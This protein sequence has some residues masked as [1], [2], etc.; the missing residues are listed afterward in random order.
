MEAAALAGVGLGLAALLR[1][2]TRAAEPVWRRAAPLLVLVL[3][4]LAVQAAGA[5]WWP[6]T[7]L[8]LPM[9]AL[10]P[11]ALAVGVAEGAVGGLRMPAG[12]GGDLVR[13][14]VHGAAGARGASSADRVVGAAWLSPL[15][16]PAWALGL[17][18]LPPWP[19]LVLAPI[20]L[21]AAGR[22]PAETREAA[23]APMEPAFQVVAT[24]LAGALAHVSGLGYW[25]SEGLIAWP[26]PAW[27]LTLAALGVALVADAG[28]LAAVLAASV[29][30]GHLP[31][32]AALPIA[33]GLAWPGPPAAR[34][35]GQPVLRPALLAGALPALAIA[36]FLERV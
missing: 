18:T 11:A 17:G 22:R 20:A 19:A 8:T 5:S 28:I 13:G 1:P 31:A 26:V 24:L 15:A 4:A 10:A 35:A 6:L 2:H 16:N 32:E 9:L 14:L 7:P 3:T 34:A 33:L 27:A 29:S 12:P 25:A 30:V 36:S 23:P 21:L